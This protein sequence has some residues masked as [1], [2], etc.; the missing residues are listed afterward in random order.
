MRL[1]HLLV[2]RCRLS[3]QALTLLELVAAFAAEQVIGSHGSAAG[4]AAW[5]C[6]G[7]AGF[8]GGLCFG[9]DTGCF[10][11]CGL[12]FGLCLQALS[13]GLLTCFFG[14]LGCG[15]FL[16]GLGLGT[17]VCGQFLGFGSSTLARLLF[18]KRLFGG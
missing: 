9:A 17:L 14:S 1:R 2:K 7:L 10:T 4:G 11:L 18:G 3:I 16:C 6:L 5:R 15:A 13:L 12:L 8:L